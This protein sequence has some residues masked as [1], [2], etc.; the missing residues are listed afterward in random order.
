MHAQD[1]DVPEELVQLA[2]LVMS[3]VPS[4][5]ALDS[6]RGRVRERIEA[7]DDETLR[8]LYRA[9]ESFLAGF[10]QRGAGS[11]EAAERSF[12]RA[13]ELAERV[14]ARAERSEA[15]RVMSEAYNQLLDIRG[16]G[17][18]LVTAGRARAA[19]ERAVALDETNPFAHLTA[20]AYFIGA[21]GIAGGD[22]RRGARHLEDAARLAPD[23]EYVDFL[24]SVWRAHLA[25]KAGDRAAAQ[26][27]IARAAGIYPGNWWLAAVAAELDVPL[28]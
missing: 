12:E 26:R 13:I 8:M 21:P 2:L 5:A 3:D 9:M 10:A 1:T 24:V 15:F 7:V 23:S 22:D 27:W 25:S 18:R 14:N 28:P 17:Y 6:A 16:T 11:V 20:A 19:A 4:Q